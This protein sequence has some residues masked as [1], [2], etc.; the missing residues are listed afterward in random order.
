MSV[1]LLR[2]L[3]LRLLTSVILAV[4]LKVVPIKTVHRKN[5]FHVPFPLT[6]TVLGW[7]QKSQVA[8]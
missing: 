7:R 1:Y 4:A 5:P 3:G 8:I 2:E 6:S